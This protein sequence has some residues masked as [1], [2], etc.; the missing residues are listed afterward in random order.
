MSFTATWMGLV[1][2]ILS[3]VSQKRKINT[4]WY[5]LYVESKM[6][7]IWIYL[8][9]RNRLTDIENRLVVVK[10]GGNGIYGEFGVSNLYLLHL[11]WISNEVLLYSTGNYI[12]SLGVEGEEDNKRKR[13]HIYVYTH[14]Y[15]YFYLYLSTIYLSLYLPIIYIIGSLCCTA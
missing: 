3:E 12:Q 2:L 6:R 7:H 8:K 4:M 5:S 14:T 15:I 13:I 1:S 11:E 10:K 9:N